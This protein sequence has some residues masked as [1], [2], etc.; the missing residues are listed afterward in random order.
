MKGFFRLSLSTYIIIGLLVFY[1]VYY[2]VVRPILAKKRLHELHPDGFP[3]TYDFYD[4]MLVII[5]STQSSDET[6]RLKYA[7]VQRKI[8]ERKYIIVLS[9][10]KRNRLGLYKAVMTSEDLER[11]R[12]HLNERCPQRKT[13]A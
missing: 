5:S 8:K 3:V 13:G 4:D 11:V 2:I 9:T 1:A 12:R 7:D 6:V 10:V